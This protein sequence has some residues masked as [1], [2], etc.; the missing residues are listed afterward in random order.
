MLVAEASGDVRVLARL[1]QLQNKMQ[2]VGSG[3]SYG[4][5]KY[6]D[7]LLYIHA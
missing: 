6:V 1:W 5:A 4:V 7:S 3:G 2:S